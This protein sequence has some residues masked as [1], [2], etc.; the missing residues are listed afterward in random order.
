MTRRFSSQ[1]WSSRNR[2]SCSD[3]CR[4]VL[5]HA[6]L[7][8]ASRDGCSA[9]V[10]RQCRRVPVRARA[11]RVLSILAAGGRQQQV[12]EGLETAAL[13]RIRD[14]TAPADDLV[15]Q[16]TFGAVPGCDALAQVAIQPPEIRLD[17]AEVGQQRARV[18]AN[19]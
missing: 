15:E 10:G 12:V 1:T 5:E 9:A 14:V 3:S 8:Q 17:L 7:R 6:R 2:R 19:C 18:S 4:T 11:P 16:L 13:V